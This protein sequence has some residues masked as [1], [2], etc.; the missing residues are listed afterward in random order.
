MKI[1]TEDINELFHLVIKKFE[2][3]RNIFLGNS[4][5]KTAD[6]FKELAVFINEKTNSSLSSDTLYKQ[7]FIKLKSYNFPTIGYSVSYLNAFTQLLY[8]V[9]YTKKYQIEIEDTT[10]IPEFPYEPFIACFPSSELVKIEVAEHKNV[11]IKN[12]S[13]N[14]TGI[15][16]DRMAWEIYL[17]YDSI[18][19]TKSLEGDR[20]SLPRLSIIST[21]NAALAIQYLLRQKGLPDLKVIVDKNISNEYYSMLENSRCEIYKEDLQAGPLS[22][23]K[24]KEITN[25]VGG[26]DITHGHDIDN[27]KATYYDWL[28]YEVLNTNP[29]HVFIPYGTGDLFK[30][31]IE[32][33]FAE[34][35][36]RRPSKRFFGNRNILSRCNFYGAYTT[37]PKTEMKMLYTPFYTADE[38]DQKN[39][40]KSGK[41]GSA[42]NTIEV[43]EKFVDHALQ[44]FGEYRIEAEPSGA[45]G[46]ALFLQMKSKIDIND[47]VVIVNTG[48]LKKHLFKK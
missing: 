33:L 38:N 11:W 22:A 4:E 46:L 41:I 13:T 29:Q 2:N 18:I 42:S 26:L 34:F 39:L 20:I 21:G 5:V 31:I 35:D 44:I 47:K 24:I 40:L 32:I 16:K 23:E 14:P 3:D 43:Q 7:Y 12:E 28:S 37:N 8:N 10:E 27:I 9:E 25:N 45:A 1:F 6:F 15:H 48:K 17:N 30:N 19:R 36:R